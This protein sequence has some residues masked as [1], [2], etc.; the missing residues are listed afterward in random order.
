MLLSSVHNNSVEE[1]LIPSLLA[2]VKWSLLRT[3]LRIPNKN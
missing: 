1:H 3:F 2:L